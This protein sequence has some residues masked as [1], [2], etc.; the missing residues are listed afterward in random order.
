[1]STN[2]VGLALL[3]VGLVSL[4]LE[5]GAPPAEGLEPSHPEGWQRFRLQRDLPHLGLM[6]GRNYLVD[7]EA[8]LYLGDPV[9]VRGEQGS[10]FLTGFQDEWMGSVI[11]RVVG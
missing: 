9:V 8:L 2:S 6:R 3:T 7:P 5:R 1:M 10:V 4:L 11:G